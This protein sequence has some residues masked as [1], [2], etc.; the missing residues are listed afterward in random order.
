MISVSFIAFAGVVRYP[1]TF[2]SCG[3]LVIVIIAALSAEVLILTSRPSRASRAKEYFLDDCIEAGEGGR[4]LDKGEVFLPWHMATDMGQSESGQ[5]RW[6]SGLIV[7][8][9]NLL[10][11]ASTAI[12][13]MSIYLFAASLVQETILFFTVMLIVSVG[14]L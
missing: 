7:F 10:L 3:T 2:D 11:L 9:L 1:F 4:R 14:V 5:P 13:G 6:S 12:I 8:S